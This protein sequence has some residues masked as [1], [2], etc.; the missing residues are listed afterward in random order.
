MRHRSLSALVLLISSAAFGLARGDGPLPA[1]PA[2][3][4]KHFA[5]SWDDATWVPE[6]GLGAKQYMRPLDDPGWKARMRVFQALVATG[7]A[8]VAPLVDALREGSTAERI[9]AAQALGYLAEPAAS[10]ALA[11]A[12]EHDPEA[13]VRLYAVDSLGMLEGDRHAE[14]FAR[15]AEKESNRDVKRHLAYAIARGDAPLDP[16]VARQLVEWDERQLDSTQEGQ[17]A[18]DFELL[19]LNGQRVRLSDY[20]GRSAIVL[21]FV[22]GDT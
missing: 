18:P 15:L 6:R 14:L 17:S 22:Y 20:R 10:E 9:L 11:H 19:A 21:V 16:A 12:A 8:S 1:E 5:A 2:A 4:L 7:K 3:L 13:V